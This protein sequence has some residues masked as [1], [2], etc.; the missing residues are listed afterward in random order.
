MYTYSDIKL[1]IQMYGM[2]TSDLVSKLK[3]TRDPVNSRI[4]EQVDTME[5]IEEGMVTVYPKVSLL[6]GL[7]EIQTQVLSFYDTFIH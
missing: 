5:S 7:K 2:S 1:Y 6:I 4:N 3:W